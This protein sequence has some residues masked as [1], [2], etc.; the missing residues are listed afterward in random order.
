[1]EQEYAIVALVIIIT[2][3]TTATEMFKHYV[4]IKSTKHDKDNDAE[5]SMLRQQNKE[6]QTRI[7]T[8]ETIVT[9]PG[10]DLKQTINGL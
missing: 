3:G 5:I 4:K 6:L 10:Y 9:E 1:M 8:L 7:A 2:L